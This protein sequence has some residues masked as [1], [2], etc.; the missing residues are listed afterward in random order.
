MFA[1]QSGDKAKN[2]TLDET[3]GI[4]TFTIL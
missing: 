3:L 1:I 2:K 4:V